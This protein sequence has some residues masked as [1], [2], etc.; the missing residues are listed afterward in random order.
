MPTVDAAVGSKINRLTEPAKLRRDI[1]LREE[2]CIF[3]NH[4][5]FNRTCFSSII[6]SFSENLTTAI[7]NGDAN[8]SSF[9]RDDPSFR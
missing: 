7:S 2:I 8:L 4:I 1:V 6:P 5:G 3:N 9:P